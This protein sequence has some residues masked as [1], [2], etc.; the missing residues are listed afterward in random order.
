VPGAEWQEEWM[1]AIRWIATGLGIALAAAAQ[2][3]QYKW[4]DKN[5]RTQYGDV[6]P[7]GVKAIPL[8]APAGPAVQAAPKGAKKAPL[9][10]AEQE[11]ELRRRQKEKDDA[12]AKEAQAKQAAEAEKQNCENARQVLRTLESGQRITRTDEKG[13]RYFLEDAQIAQETARAREAV[14]SWC[15]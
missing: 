12:A 10:P 3:Q 1:K 14:S 6:P 11:L 4:V 5:G 2:A 8:R 7:P 13:E 15:K 9:T